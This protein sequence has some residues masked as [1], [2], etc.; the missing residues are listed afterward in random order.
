MPTDNCSVACASNRGSFQILADA[1]NLDHTE[2]LRRHP[3][4]IKLNSTFARTALGANVDVGYVR[5]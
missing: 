2:A 3:V 4:E 5:T 1:Y